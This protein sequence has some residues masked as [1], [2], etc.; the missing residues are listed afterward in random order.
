MADQL[1]NELKALAEMHE[2]GL[3]TD[4]EFTTAKKRA[5]EQ[6]ASDSTGSTDRNAY[7]APDL[8][9]TEEDRVAAPEPRSLQGSQA[10][11]RDDRP[12]ASATGGR[13]RWTVTAV[14]VA[15]ALVGIAIG[16]A[17][18]SNGSDAVATGQDEPEEEAAPEE[19]EASV[20]TEPVE[21]SRAQQREI[22]DFQAEGYVFDCLANGQR[23]LG[24]IHQ[25]NPTEGE[26]LALIIKN[27]F[28][29]NDPLPILRETRPG[30]ISFANLQVLCGDNPYVIREIVEW[31]L[32]W[33][34]L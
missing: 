4:D 7:P 2:S 22:L 24:W 15:A 16:F 19:S 8:P 11:N 34:G 13:G 14:L 10:E 27:A 3:L 29:G 26:K 18:S 5:F 20:E 30:T 17:V 33:Y 32:E 6:A 23:N 25:G 12:S 21:M 9:G 1:L 31:G 28:G